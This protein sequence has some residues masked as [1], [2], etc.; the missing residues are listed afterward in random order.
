MRYIHVESKTLIVSVRFKAGRPRLTIPLAPRSK[1]VDLK[2]RTDHPLASAVLDDVLHPAM[3]AQY[4]R[5]GGTGIVAYSLV[6]P[7]PWL[8]AI[9]LVMWEGI[10]QGM[11]WD[12]VKLSVRAGL[13]ELRRHRAAPPP[14]TSEKKAF[15]LGFSWSNYANGQKQKEMF[16]GLR[17]RYERSR[18]VKPSVKSLAMNNKKGGVRSTR[19][20]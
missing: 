15:E 16:L 12:V 13:K 5:R 17:T 6:P 7:D 19:S 9:A 14:G 10:L 4:R 1:A 18:Q 11:S 8:V 2:P 3:L 20:T